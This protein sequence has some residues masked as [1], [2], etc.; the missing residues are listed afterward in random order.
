MGLFSSNNFSSAFS[1]GQ[2]YIIS[3]TKYI[4]IILA[5]M[6][7]SSLAGFA[8]SAMHFSLTSSTRPVATIEHISAPIV[9]QA[10]N[11]LQPQT[12]QVDQAKVVPAPVVEP[13]SD[14]VLAEAI[15]IDTLPADEIIWSYP[16]RDTK[17]QTVI[18]SIET[19]Q[20][21][22]DAQV[23]P[24]TYQAPET[25]RIETPQPVWYPPTPQYE[26]PATAS[27]KPRYLIGVY[28]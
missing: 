4:S 20:T 2:C 12:V 9:T 10:A 7:L 17:Q 13:V 21:P 23:L 16:E 1:F 14:I 25:T 8:V 22:R 6:A 11:H 3:M 15:Y 18:K 24:E 28:R 19:V 26:Y 27:P 5:A